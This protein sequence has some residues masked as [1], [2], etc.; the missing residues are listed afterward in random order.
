[1]RIGSAYSPAVHSLSSGR[2]SCCSRR[3]RPLVWRVVPPP[4]GGVTHTVH[5][6]RGRAA[7]VFECL[8]VFACACMRALVCRMCGCNQ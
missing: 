4:P 1:M 8:D 5:L 7:P 6:P 2:D 3:G